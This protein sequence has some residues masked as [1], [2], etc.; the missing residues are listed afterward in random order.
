LSDI[1]YTYNRRGQ[2]QI[3]SKEDMK[4]R[5]SRSPDIADALLMAFIPRPKTS[6]RVRV[7]RWG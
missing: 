2:L 4:K 1:R 6:H 3:E 7:Q 5:G